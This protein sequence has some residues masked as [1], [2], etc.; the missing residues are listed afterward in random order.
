MAIVRKTLS[1]AKAGNFAAM[2]LY[3]RYLRSPPPR[4][5]LALAFSYTRPTSID[6]AREAILDLGV[7]LARGELTIETHDSLIAGLR[8]YLN[9]RAAEQQK[10]LEEFE[11]EF[12][13]RDPHRA[14]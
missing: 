1:E 6:A 13:L 12:E 11:A 7:R 5:T 8:A 2:K 4:M 3:Y 10:R 9:D 14:S